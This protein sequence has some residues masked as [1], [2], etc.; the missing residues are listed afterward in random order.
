MLATYLKQLH[1]LQQRGD[2]REESFY[3]IFAALLS[4]YAT[5]AGMP[6]VHITILPRKTDAGNPDLRIWDGSTH[7]VGYIEAKAPLVEDLDQIE[8]GDQMQ[9]YLRAFPNVVLTNF[10]HFRLYRNGTRIADVQI[11]R[12]FATRVLKCVP[13]VEH[14]EEFFNLLAQFFSFS[15]PVV[16]DAAAL[17]QHLALRTRFLNDAIAAELA[18]DIARG[19]GNILSFFRAFRE[20][21]I[22]DLTEGDFADLYAQ[23]VT[24]G[25]FA[26]RTRAKNGFNRKAAFDCIPHTIGVLRDVFRFISL[27]EISPQMEW[28]VD[29]IADVLAVTDVQAILHQYFSEHKGADPI[30]HFY[31]T[32]LAA[33]DP[34]MRER[35][36]VYYTVEPV[37]AY[38]DRSL[39]AL[40]QTVFGKRDGLADR[41]VIILDFAG[42]TETFNAMAARIAVE[43]FVAN[44]GAGA[45]AAFIQQHILEHFYA[46]E[47]MMAPYA[48]GHIKMSFLLEELGYKLTD[49]DR[50]KF[51][52]T[53]TLELAELKESSLPGLAALS[54]E[55]HLAACVKKETPVLVI[56]GNPPYSGISANMND[57]IVNLL[58]ENYAGLQSYYEIDGAPL[59]EKKVWLQDD[60]VKF[61]RFAQWKIA[62]RG[63]GMI[64]IITNHS[65]LD[66]PTFRGMRQSLLRTFDEIYI[67]DL[68]GNAK[69]KEVSPDG[70]KDENVFDIQ[71]GVCIAIMVKHSAAGK[72]THPA[73]A[74]VHQADLW[75]TRARKYEWLNH[76]TVANTKWRTL[77]P[78]APFYFFVR[79]DET[80]RVTYEKYP[81]LPAIFPINVTG[82][83]TARDHFVV[84]VNKDALLRRVAQF[85]SKNFS[86]DLIQR[87]FKLKDTRGWKLPIARHAVQEDSNWAAH[88]VPVLY[89]P[90]DVRWLYY[91][92]SMVDW[93][94]PDIMRQMLHPNVSLCFMRQVSSG[95]AYTHV[96]ASEHMVDNRTFF[97]SRGIIQQAPLYLYPD[98][99]PQTTRE[100]SASIRQALMLFEPEAPYPAAHGKKVNVAPAV[101]QTC[102]KIYGRKLTPETLFSYIYAVLYMPAY[103]EKYAEFLKSDFPR[104]PFTADANLFAKVAR[105][106]EVLIEQ[107]LLK[108]SA[109]RDA[110]VKFHG[111]GDFRVTALRYDESAARMYINATQYF[112]RVPAPVWDYQMGGYHVCVKWLKDRKGRVLTL[113]ELDHYARIIAALQRSREVQADLDAFFADVEKNTVSFA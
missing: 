18:E 9:R 10:Y 106:G 62:Q 72:T 12:P 32:F 20:Y 79:R 87:T 90:F 85:R 6:N 15:F 51:Y 78:N 66:N 71:Q 50:F 42:G 65:Y 93:G 96:L 5:Q 1:E 33:Y 111:D 57:W 34:K 45:R 83:V 70:T 102:Q 80:G 26:A 36:G 29:D 46:F 47:L 16:R 28:I 64:G 31:E 91:T 52:L 105:L 86:D 101:W 25:F 13:P 24:Y 100:R 109:R 94:R 99:M 11:G 68:H 27:G 22:H 113:D 73:D 112:E 81:A 107:H 60:Y 77:K 76:H 39:H 89:R 74:T 92:A 49:K 55:S 2:A 54:E 84:D 58:K 104:V 103:R 8:T 44:H 23:T 14:A 53:N 21:L 63:E 35:R 95:E 41:S 3:G 48:I 88:C 43:T 38:I 40:L 7:V 37:V 4:A 17:A 98:D 19:K 59:G 30:V 108:G 75:G 82:I 56:H 61:I 97:S 110:A 67:L 69:K